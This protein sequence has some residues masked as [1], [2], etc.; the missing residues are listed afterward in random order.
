MD[1]YLQIKNLIKE[2][3][4]FGKYQILKN[5]VKNKD[6]QIYEG[7]N[8]ITEELITIKIEQKKDK[9]KKGILEIESHYLNYLKSPGFPTIM[10]MRY[11]DNN[12]IS[13]QPL[14]GL[15][16]FQLF[17][18][19]YGNFKIKD[20]IM[21]AIQILERIKFIH[22][23]NIIHCNINPNNFAL[24]LGKFQNL[25]FMTNFQMA[26]R[27]RDKNTLE[28]IKYNILNENGFNYI[29]ASVNALRGVEF[30]RRDD[31]ES[32]GYMLIYFLKGG[33]PWEHIKCLNN[34][35]KKK[36]NLPG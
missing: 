26:K 8:I 19:Y 31:L 28:H 14:L 35:E 23:K 30:S 12:I 2:K 11:F 9:K 6:L 15:N 20:I 34:S 27:Y 1:S 25:I 17:T 5:I 4:I 18:K 3:I 7:K 33:L 32:L 10:K 13:I 22:N 36:K 29:F 16:L 21:I 24:G